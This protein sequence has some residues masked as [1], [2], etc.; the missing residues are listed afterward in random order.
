MPLPSPST[1]SSGAPFRLAM[2]GALGQVRHV[3]TVPVRSA[4]GD[5]ARV[6]SAVEA[7]F[8]LLAPPVAL[9]A[10]APD[11]LVA[12]WSLLRESLLV[13]GSVPRAEREAVATGVSLANECP[14]CVQ[15]HASVLGGLQPGT[16]AHG[17]RSGDLSAVTDP[18]LREL[19]L[20]ARDGGPAPVPDGD[21]PEL[22]A[23]VLAFHYLNRMV[24]VFLGPS[25][26]PAGLPSAVGGFAAGVLGRMLAPTAALRR[27]PEASDG[28]RDAVGLPPDLGWASPRSVPARAVTA[29]DRHGDRVL[30]PAERDAVHR[31][32]AVPP[33]AGTPVTAQRID[34][35]LADVP[36]GRRA[37]ARLALLTAIAPY[38]V[39]DTV[40]EAYRAATPGRHGDADVLAV[41]AWAALAAAR[42]RTGRLAAQQQAA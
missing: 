40:V 16:G 11:L 34:G 17:L 13:S 42:E 25:P 3:S 31:A 18:R 9:H 4:A 1:R 29:I 19:V 33:A 7:E 5:V 21:V 28:A 35:L 26:L 37:A 32:L 22:L 41:T 15:V 23:V 8:G 30:G 6:Y 38:R 36:A 12:A 2:R 24:H 39:D 20:W 27:A 10:P 14:Y